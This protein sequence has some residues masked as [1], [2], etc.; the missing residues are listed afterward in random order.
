M[1][2]NRFS[3]ISSYQCVIMYMANILLYYFYERGLFMFLRG[4]KGKMFSVYAVLIIFMLGISLSFIITLLNLGNN[5]NGFMQ[6]NYKSIV[7]AQDMM[8]ALDQSQQAALG[9]IMS[10]ETSGLKQFSD[11]SD[12]FISAYLVEKGNIT[13]KGESDLVA[14]IN[15][16][17]EN[18][19]KSF[20][21][22]QEYKSG[23]GR[24]YSLEYFYNTLVKQYAALKSDCRNL[25][26]M[27]QNAM[28]A[29]ADRINMSAR[30]FIY[31]NIVV[32]VITTVLGFTFIF[33]LLSKIFSPLRQFTDSVRSIKEGNLYNEIHVNSNDE[34][35]ELAGEFNSMTTRLQQY[36]QMNIKK[37]VDEKNKSSAIV[38]SIGDPIIVTDINYKIILLNPSFE[39]IFGIKQGDAYGKHF[40]EVINNRHIF[41]IITDV[42]H[43]GDYM[44]DE[45]I[46][47][48]K[49]DTKDKYYK[50]SVTP[51][52]D[53]DKAITGTVT[54][55][56]DIT[57]LKE[58]EILK[59][60]FVSTVSHE[61][62]TP[63]T[64]I[65]LGVGL[66]LDRTLGAINKDQNEVISAIK[67]EEERLANLVND[68]LDLSR[69]ESG[70]MAINKKPC[71]IEE[72]I[73]S[74]A[75][76][77]S[78]LAHTRGVNLNYYKD[79]NIP[80]VKADTD[81]IR[82]VLANLIGNAIK[83][84]PQGGNIEVFTYSRDK[85]VY[86]SVKDTGIGI[87][88][89]Y[90]EKIFERFVQ[91]KKNIN[92]GTGTGLGLAIA[93]KI[94]EAH[95]GEIWVESEEGKGSTF[96]FTLKMS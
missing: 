53:K 32:A 68:L 96:T 46:L 34:I 67:D 89:E 58:V 93:K 95:G 29:S 78:E 48:L 14:K 23:Q 44:S 8:D 70:K 35:G 19:N 83:F 86:I 1:R 40:L 84:T 18:Y 45:D 39:S 66:L 81:K 13:E 15:S 92:D 73:E 4:I 61:F 69:I 79:E 55:L 7:A 2:N 16:S 41:D 24:D 10:D 3:R 20:F 42:L 6:A 9:F 74:T 59:S 57:H 12:N 37:L 38:N 49:L 85:K 94:V 52:Y 82:T 88:K 91:V 17:Y 43:S 77:L 50:V 87:P 64:S 56:Q 72:I 27:N 76:S 11:S 51:I 25:M 47:S 31:I 63:L 22:L 80:A 26:S 30:N 75:K 33:Y 90:H 21:Q 60:E 71:L 65:S 28:F 5:I 62:R 54:L 36:D